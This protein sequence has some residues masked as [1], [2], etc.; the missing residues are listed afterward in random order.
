MEAG[1]NKRELAFKAM[2]GLAGGAIGWLPVEIASHG[3]SLTEMP[4]TV[5]MVA[6]FVSMAILSGLIG[7]LVNAAEVQTLEYNPT[8]RRRFLIGFGICFLMALPAIYYAN[9]VF[10][11]FLAA[12][13]WGV[14]RAGSLLNLIVGRTISW[15]L[16]GVMLGAGVGLATFSIRNV[17]KG[18]IGGWVGGFVS[19][20]VFDPI[21]MGL[22]ASG[23]MSRLVGFSVTGSAIGLFIGLVQELTKSAWLTVEAGRLRGRQ[24]RLEHGVSFVGRAEENAVGLFG[25]PAVLARHAQIARHG[26]SYIL[27]SLSPQQ[28]VFVNGARIESV[29]LHDGDRIA[30]GNYELGFHLRRTP[31]AMRRP[32]AAPRPAPPRPAS[33]PSHADA[34][35]QPHLLDG[36]GRSYQVVPGATTTLGRGL[37]NDIVVAH[38]SVSRHHANILNHDGVYQLVDL[39][40]RN[41]TFVG[42]KRVAEAQIAN[43]DTIRL[44]DAQFIFRA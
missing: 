36:D 35:S 33:A 21:G 22:S 41:G 6:N 9:A 4:T 31:G 28:G 24:F 42:G 16:L 43:G 25:D 3:H 29:E 5:G 14:N 20:L 30:I 44:G 19:G 17:G 37:D 40:S 1:I 18:A 32:I 26:D 12:G 8:T 27:K 2:A 38:A 23:L 7:G 11:Y 34:G 13:G 39:Q 15:A 10:S